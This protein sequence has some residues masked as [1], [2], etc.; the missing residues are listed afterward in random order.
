MRLDIEEVD[1][2]TDETLDVL[3][4]GA[5]AGVRKQHQLGVAE[6]LVQVV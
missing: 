4:V 3:E 6:V 1:N 5:M 2:P